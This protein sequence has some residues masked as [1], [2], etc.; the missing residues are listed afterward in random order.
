MREEEAFPANSVQKETDIT[1][2]TQDV[3][4]EANIFRHRIR[5]RNTDIDSSS[6]SRPETNT[7]ICHPRA[8]NRSDCVGQSVQQETDSNVSQTGKRKGRPAGRKD[9]YK[10]KR[11]KTLDVQLDKRPSNE[12]TTSMC[13]IAQQI[14]NCSASQADDFTMEVRRD[15]L[16]NHILVGENYSCMCVRFMCL[17]KTLHADVT[18]RVERRQP[19]QSIS[20]NVSATENTTADEQQVEDTD[21]E[22]PGRYI[23]AL[24]SRDNGIAVNTSNTGSSSGGGGGGGGGGDD[25]GD[26][27][28]DDGGDGDRNDMN[29]SDVED[30]AAND[31]NNNN[32]YDSQYIA[33]SGQDYDDSDDENYCPATDNESL[34]D[35]PSSSSRLP[36]RSRKRGRTLS[37]GTARPSDRSSDREG[38]PSR[39]SRK[40]IENPSLSASFI[41]RRARMRDAARSSDRNSDREDMPS[42]HSRERIARP[43]S[44]WSRSASED[45]S[46]SVSRDRSRS[47]SRNRNRSNSASRNESQVGQKRMS[48]AELQQRAEVEFTNM[49]DDDLVFYFVQLYGG[50]K[51]YNRNLGK[52]VERHGLAEIAQNLWD[53]RRK[54]LEPKDVMENIEGCSVVGI[55]LPLEDANGE[56]VENRNG[57][58][59][60]QWFIGKIDRQASTLE[61]LNLS[62]FVDGDKKTLTINEDQNDF[63][64]ATREDA[65]YWKYDVF[66]DSGF[67]SL[68]S[69]VKDIRNSIILSLSSASPPQPLSQPLLLSL[70]SSASF[71]AS[72]QPLLLNHHL[73]LILTITSALPQPYLSLTLPFLILH[74]PPHPPQRPPQR[75]SMLAVRVQ[76]PG[77]GVQRARRVIVARVLL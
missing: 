7:G 54:C 56:L 43:S 34:L 17:T 74:P 75:T 51:K 44:S 16:R 50:D 42:R 73:S 70:F 48:R 41:V 21:I 33:D 46:R 14:F 76:N 8:S 61:E 6:N 18:D 24:L 35:V 20:H 55:W 3:E 28:G 39:R 1:G 19:R 27:G 71:S 77:P 63:N 5:H 64:S 62:G 12:W 10:R 57:R 45:R 30:Q 58:V 2:S 32:G 11:R 49:S 67:E 40:R 69:K 72:P 65:K 60:K 36:T 23:R 25:D 52:A 59:K 26:D 9:T 38:M 47:T 22:Q 13:K 66:M 29:D 31:N 37:R 53:H 4:E 68:K 15:V